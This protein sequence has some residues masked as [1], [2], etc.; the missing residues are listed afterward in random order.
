[1]ANRTCCPWTN[2]STTAWQRAIAEYQNILHLWF[3]LLGRTRFETDSTSTT[4]T[5]LGRWNNLPPL[6]R[7]FRDDFEIIRHTLREKLL[8]IFLPMRDPYHFSRTSMCALLPESVARLKPM[9]LSRVSWNCM[10]KTIYVEN[11]SRFLSSRCVLIVFTT[12]M[13]FIVFYIGRVVSI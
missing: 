6:V 10:S 2:C 11:F 9:L 4:L 1:M 12:K 8:P 5:E 7:Q 13:F 3:T